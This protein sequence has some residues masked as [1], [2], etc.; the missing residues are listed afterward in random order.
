[1]FYPYQKLQ[2][3]TDEHHGGGLIFFQVIMWKKNHYKN[4]FNL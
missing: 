1:M 4:V 2:S 3:L